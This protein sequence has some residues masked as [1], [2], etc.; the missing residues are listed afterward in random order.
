MNLLLLGM[1][2][3]SGIVIISIHQQKCQETH[4]IQ[5]AVHPDECNSKV[6]YESSSL[7]KEWLDNVQDWQ[8][9]FCSRM[10]RFDAQVRNWLQGVSMVGNL[11]K[12]PSHLDTSIFSSYTTTYTCGTSTWEYK[13]W[14]E[15]LSHGLRHP[16]SLCNR[17]A[18]LVD[19]EYLLLVFWSEWEK[20]KQHV[21]CVGRPCQALYFDLGASTWNSGG[22]GPSQ[23]WFVDKY[24]RHGVVFDRILMWEAESLPPSQ[25][26]SQV[27]VDMMHKYQYFNVPASTDIDSPFSPLRVLINL[28]QPGDFVLFKL[29]IDNGAVEGKIVDDLLGNSTLLGLIDEFVYEYHVDFKEMIYA[30]GSTVDK[31]KS[32]YDAYQLFLSLRRKGIRAHSWV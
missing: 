8:H 16:N 21:K 26:F 22:G 19:R 7:E 9:S 14:I 4:H 20:Q 17:G 27:P 1:T 2:I 23:S 6:V 32:L 30:W 11:N 5:L 29:D 28:A 31:S 12:T 15:P 25:I 3:F 18:S 10:P 13:S 24:K